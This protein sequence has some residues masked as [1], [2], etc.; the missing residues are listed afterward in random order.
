MPKK[1]NG[2]KLSAKQ[3]RQWRHVFESTGSGAAAT[4]AVKKSIRKR[5]KTRKGRKKK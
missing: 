4:S 2:K 3:H 5:K 1:I